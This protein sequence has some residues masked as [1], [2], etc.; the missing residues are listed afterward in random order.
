MMAETIDRA[1]DTGD[2][3]DTSSAPDACR[4]PPYALVVV[5]TTLNRR[6]T[7]PRGDELPGD[8]E[9]ED[10]LTRM[11][12]Y[13]VSEAM[14]HMLRVGHLVWVPFGGRYL[15]GVVAGFD[16]STPVDE[17]AMRDIDQIADPEPVLSLAHLELARWMSEYYLAPM[18]WVIQSMIPPGVNQKAENEFVA[19]TDDEIPPAAGGEPVNLTPTQREVLETLRREGPLTLSEIARRGGV[20]SRAGVVDQLLSL[21]LVA[22]RIRVSAP[23]VKPRME[24]VVRLRSDLSEDD[25]PPRRAPKQR[26]AIEFLQAQ[27]AEGDEWILA[28]TVTRRADVTMAVIHALVEKGLLETAQRQVWRDPLEGREFVP[29]VPPRLTADQDIVWEQ[30]AADLERPNGR[31]LLLQGVTGSGKTE[32]YLRAVQHVLAR[33]QGAIVLVPE[34]ALTPQTIRRFGARFPTTLAVMHSR[35]SPGERYDQWRRIRAGELC[36]V[37]GSRSAIFAPVRD[38]GLVVLDEEHEP[39]YKQA[40]APRYHAREVALQLCRIRGATCILGSATPSL[41][42]AY[43]AERGEY[44][45][46]SMPRRIMGHRTAVEQQAAA[47]GRGQTRYQAESENGDDAL[48]TDLPPVEVVDMRAELRAGNTSIFSAALKSAMDAA[49]GAGEQVILFLNRR[50][51]ATFVMCRDCGHVLKCPRCDVPLTYHSSANNLVCH[52]CNYTTFLPTQCPNCW[53]SRIRHFGIG[54][55]RV[56]ELVREAYPAARVVR[57]DLDTTG[58][59]T[60]HEELLDRFIHGEAD[61]MVGTQMI[62]KGLDLPR[63][64]L[65]GVITADTGLNLPDLYADERTFQILT[66]VA[67]RAG[68][69]VLGGKVVVQTYTPQHPAVQA[70][71]QHD[72]ESFYEHEI[73]FRREHWYPPLSR[74]IRLIYRHPNAARAQQEATRM[75]RALTLKI[76][77]LGLANV[78]LIGPAPAFFARTRGKARWHILVRGDDPHAL[79][80]DER[81]P[82]GWSV[83]VDPV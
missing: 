35:L 60:S 51:A 54:T 66:Q 5:D 32:I 38:L 45:R 65:V 57:W 67:G 53:S 2:M 29:V 56:E 9:D 74:I 41:E 75:H 78:N 28:S 46:L 3:T 1:D 40:R 37:V 79:L 34:I 69:S 16:E 8:E 7:T 22:R 52:H 83:D 63:V 76:A 24:T 17:A 13:R 59:K 25:I 62:A 81:L 68:R 19:V 71:A 21:G 20:K 12:H 42:S 55:Q 64:T 77:R 27:Q 61:I 26:A 33:G 70:A 36:L 6:V 18:P 80:R 48:H 31:P 73:A 23:Q 47:L 44:I 14:R 30:V 58:G 72:Y 11:F 43:R 4:T 49:L 10:I 50:G 15:Q 82:L 39:S